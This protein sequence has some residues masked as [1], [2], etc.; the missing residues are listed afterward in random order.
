MINTNVIVKLIKKRVSSKLKNPIYT[1][2]INY[3]KN[4][5]EQNIVRFIRPLLGRFDVR[6]YIP[7]GPSCTVD[8]EV[9]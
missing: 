3:I 5:N 9:L 7:S 2:V 6:Q 1:K 8:Y 4:L